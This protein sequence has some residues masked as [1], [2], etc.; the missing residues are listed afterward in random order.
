MDCFGTCFGDAEMLS[1]CEDFDGDGLG[2]PPNDIYC[3]A[4]V[5]ENW[6]SDCSDQDG[7]LITTFP[8]SFY[9]NDFQSSTFQDTI[10]TLYNLSSENQPFNI[11]INPLSNNGENANNDFRIYGQLDTISVEDQEIYLDVC[12]GDNTPNEFALKNV[13]GQYNGGDYHVIY[14]EIADVY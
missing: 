8:I 3:S 12:Y 11:E 4:N 1:Y 7:L 10:L 2:N 5:P 9:I 14:I 6:V 13:N